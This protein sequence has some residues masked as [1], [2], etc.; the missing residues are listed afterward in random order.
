MTGTFKELYLGD[1][2]I[3]I[4]LHSHCSG[5]TSCYVKGWNVRSG[6][7]L[8][9]LLLHLFRVLLHFQHCTG[10]ITTGSWKGRGKQY[11]QLV[12]VLYCKLPTNSKHLLAF[13]L[14][15]RP[16]F[17]LS[18]QR[19]GGGGGGGGGQCVT[20]APPYPVLSVLQ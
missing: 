19:R 14:E 9:Y 3:H 10:H 17:E 8:H 1:L 6:N 7:V 16:G 4:T 12:M 2:N 15:F 11:I 5:R 20:T 13:P 18:S